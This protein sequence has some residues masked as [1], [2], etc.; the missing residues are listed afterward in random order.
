MK[1]IL[2]VI[3]APHFYAGVVLHNDRVIEAANVVK[4]MK[5]WSRAQ[6]RDYC[7]KKRWRISV[8]TESKRYHPY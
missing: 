3:D 2:A 1:E 4:Y 6:V 7:N 8:V 5:K